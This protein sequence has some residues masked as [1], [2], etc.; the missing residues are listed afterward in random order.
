MDEFVRPTMEANGYRELHK[1]EEV[2][3]GY[4]NQEELTVMKNTWRSIK[5]A[6]DGKT[7]LLPG[8]D[9]WCFEVLARREGYPTVFDPTCSRQ[10]VVHL[11]KEHPEWQELFLFDTGFAGS[12][13]R[14]IGSKKHALLSHSALSSTVQVFP[15]LSFSRGLALRIESTPKYWESGRLVTGMHHERQMATLK[16]G[17]IVPLSEY[18]EDFAFDNNPLTDVDFLLAR[19]EQP[20]S[21]MEEFIRAV[22][23]TVE[24]YKNSAPKFI[25]KHKPLPNRREASLWP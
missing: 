14:A 17:T 23:L 20:V 7:I 15:R 24:I 1:L 16:N 12:I 11:A 9:V 18:Y 19:V 13:P 4:F 21:A 3:Y 22:G 6:A 2:P 5:R 8:R 10:T 25:P